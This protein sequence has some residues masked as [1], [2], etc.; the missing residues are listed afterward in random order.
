[1][2]P[3]LPLSV[4]FCLA[5]CSHG[6]SI[7]TTRSITPPPEPSD[8][9]LLPD[10]ALRDEVKPYARYASESLVMDDEHLT[11]NDG[12]VT[13][14][15]DCQ[16]VNATA[17]RLGLQEIQK[18]REE[19]LTFYVRPKPSFR[20]LVFRMRLRNVLDLSDEFY[21]GDA[22]DVDSSDL[23]R[24]ESEPWTAIKV[25]HYQ[26]ESRGPDSHA[27][28]VTAGSTTLSLVTHYWWLYNYEGFVVYAEGGAEILF[29]C[30]PQDL[31]APR[32]ISGVWLMAGLL[33]T[34]IVLLTLLFGV[35][36]SIRCRMKSEAA[37]TLPQYPVY[38]EFDEEVLTNIRKKVEALRSVK[39]QDGN[40]QTENP[41]VVE[42]TLLKEADPAPTTG[43]NDNLDER[44]YQNVYHVRPTP[45]VRKTRESQDAQTHYQNL[46]SLTNP[47][48]EVGDEESTERGPADDMGTEGPYQNLSSLSNSLGDAT[49]DLS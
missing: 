11:R 37:P 44:L 41:Y 35:W 30:S 21:S 29:N 26:H 31:Q 22:I 6:Q 32:V 19:A 46:S 49:N 17:S 34:A 5:V 24:S 3:V 14:M 13:G 12:Q 40:A 10:T 27:L 4:V 38:D 16:I 20:R 28:R 36:V 9:N 48:K 45:A 2:L 7:T 15:K 1:M 33:I 42:M 18:V 25:K 8:S 23:E 47:T 39:S 43:Q